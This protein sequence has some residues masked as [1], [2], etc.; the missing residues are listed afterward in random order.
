M[1]EARAKILWGDPP[2][3][4]ARYLMM[5]GFA[6]AEATELVNELFQE[7][8]ATIRGDGIKK[9]FMGIGLI[10]VPIIAWFSFMSFGR[11]F[12]KLF[13]LTIMA[14]LYGVYVLIKGIFMTMAPKSVAG[15]ASEQ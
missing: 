8:A 6:A 4:V 1:H 3:E 14:G 5:Q 13:A 2:R 15:D 12:V 10:L 7:R 11:L 9:I